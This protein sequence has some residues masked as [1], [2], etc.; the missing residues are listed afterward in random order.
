[1]KSANSLNL[2]GK[3]LAGAAQAPGNRDRFDAAGLLN[4]L[5]ELAAGWQDGF[6]RLSVLR[7]DVVRSRPGAFLVNARDVVYRGKTS[8]TTADAFTYFAGAQWNRQR[9]EAR[10]RNQSWWGLGETPV[11]NVASRLGPVGLRDSSLIGRVDYAFLTL[12]LQVVGSGPVVLRG[13]PSRLCEVAIALYRSQLRLPPGAVVAVIATGERLF[14]VQRSLLSKIFSASVVNEY[15]CQESGISGMSC[16]EAGRIHLDEDRCLY[17]VID[18]EL[19]TTDL[20]NMTMPV[21]RYVSG[22]AISLYADDCPCGRLGL[23]AKIL[24]RQAEE[25]RQLGRRATE[26]DMP[27]F[28]GLLNYQVRIEDKQRRIWVQPETVLSAEATAPLKLWFERAFGAGNTEVL[29]E[30][31]FAEMAGSVD[32]QSLN[33]QSLN[34]LSSAAWLAQVTQQKWSDWIEQPLPMGEAKDIAALLQQMVMPQQVMGQGAS[35]Q[36]LRLV[37]KVRRCAVTQNI[38][39]DVMRL[40]VLLWALSLIRESEELGEMMALYDELVAR[41]GMLGDRTQLSSFSALGFDLLAPLLTFENGAE[42]WASVYESVRNYWPSGMKAD[43]FTVHHY[44]TAVDIAGQNAQQRGH[45]WRSALRP[46]SAVLLGDFYRVGSALSVEDVMLW[47]EIVHERPGAFGADLGEDLGADLSEGW[48]ESFE[49]CQSAFRRSLLRRDQEAA[50]EQLES[51]F[52]IAGDVKET[53]QCWLEKGY[54]YLV[55]EKKFVV[56]E[57]LEIL[58]EHVGVLSQANAVSNPMPWSPILKALAP[59]LVKD[60]KHELAY[61]CLFAA[62]PPNRALSA[63]DRRSVGVNGK[64]SVLSV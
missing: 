30:S 40:R 37:Q 14:E 48:G 24:G 21:V 44:L 4:D 11:V 15:G 54:A 26:I 23:T 28:P 49:G 45:C 55:F 27:S 42:R 19:V 47:M 33:A 41:V 51:L 53:A 50:F 7:K 36:V 29:V 17:E 63:F 18:G 31:P 57:W 43:R 56:D 20:W 32:A 58:K 12:L 61:A 1:M 3:V 6:E 60:G 16:P 38:G 10:V 5:G 52:E 13:Y 35:Q 9:V 34:A 25:N 62:A 59:E 46:L 39:L 64:Q 22:D 8:G 2:L